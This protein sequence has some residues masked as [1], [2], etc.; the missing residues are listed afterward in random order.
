MDRIDL[1][2]IFVRVV[3]TASFSRAAALLNMPRSSVSTAVQELEARLGTRL[4]ARTTRSVAPTPDGRAFYDH[5]IRL[6]ADVEDAENLFRRDKASPRGTLRVDMPGRI[7]RLIV[8]PA[9]P[10]FL[11]RY[12]DIDII[13][14]VTDRAVNMI[15]DGV[16]CV[17][18]VGPLQ[19]SSLIARKIGIL[20]LIN[21]ASPA[22]LARY[23]TPETPDDLK[24]HLA[25]QYASPSTGRTED[26][27]WVE[28]GQLRTLA[29]HSRVTVNSAEALIACSLAGLGLMQIPA[30]DVRHHLDDGSLI[31]V[32]PAY[33]AEAV[34]M[35][36]LYPDR[37]HLPSRL[38]VFSD[39]L[40]ALLAVRTAEQSQTD[41]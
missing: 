23:G 24:H 32:L 5:A 7:G 36:L 39:W 6:I 29:M 2:R 3:E 21:V 9:L 8:A 12:P 18:R 14:G 26:W 33:R 35:T 38:Q 20:D 1:F 30:Y 11:E 31:D 17:I 4:L 15:E 40:T 22:Y 10:E 16:D 41:D 13:M 37:R 27:E 28:G 34:P 25:V 19:D